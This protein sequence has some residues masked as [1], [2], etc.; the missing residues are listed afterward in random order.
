MKVIRNQ[1][2][3]AMALIGDAF[4]AAFGASDTVGVS[5]AEK[6]WGARVQ[7]TTGEFTREVDGAKAR[8][9]ATTPALTQA[10]VG[11]I[12]LYV[13]QQVV[14]ALTGVN[15][16]LIPDGDVDRISDGVLD[17]MSVRLAQ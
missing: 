5:A 9:A 12:K 16:H 2:T 6:T 10:D 4:Y 7:L 8:Q 13:A 14:A 1:D 15:G 3:G 17:R 11:E